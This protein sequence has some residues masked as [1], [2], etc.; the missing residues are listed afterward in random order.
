MIKDP[1]GVGLGMVWDELILGVVI[2]NALL[3]IWLVRMLVLTL[4]LELQD[5]DQ[6]LGAAIKALI[7]QGIGDFEPPSPIQ[8]A[9][10]EVLK[11]NVLGQAPGDPVAILRDAEG[12]FSQ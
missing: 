6:K 9:L 4:R 3:M 11:N 8:V 7:E 12:K 2:F 5:L 1:V 10:A